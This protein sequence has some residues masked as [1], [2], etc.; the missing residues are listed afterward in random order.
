M[1]EVMLVETSPALCFRHLADLKSHSPC[2]EAFV[3]VWQIASVQTTTHTK[4]KVKCTFSA[5]I[6]QPLLNR[7]V[8]PLDQQ[9]K[10]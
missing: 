9:K 1:R 3:N 4:N 8:C 7:P 5:K 6:Q 2:K 10:S